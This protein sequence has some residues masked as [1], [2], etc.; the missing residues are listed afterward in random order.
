MFFEDLENRIIEGI[1]H[2][3]APFLAQ[4]PVDASLN[5]T[6]GAGLLNSDF[7]SMVRK[8]PDRN[9]GK[10]PLHQPIKWLG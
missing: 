5:V 7:S 4:S 3:L 1:R 2:E 9:Y 10:L 8:I 6:A